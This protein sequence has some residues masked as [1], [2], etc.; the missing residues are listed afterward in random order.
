MERI[1]T[2]KTDGAYCGDDT[3]QCPYT[4]KNE[5]SNIVCGLFGAHCPLMKPPKGTGSFLRNES[6]ARH[7]NELPM[8]RDEEQRTEDLLFGKSSEE[9][10]A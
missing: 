3:G 2:I 7:F 1:I 8:I 10:S 6:C 5:N 4:I 9:V